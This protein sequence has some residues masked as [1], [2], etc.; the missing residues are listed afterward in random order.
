MLVD[1]RARPIF[2]SRAYIPTRFLAV[3]P[4]HC[5]IAWSC[6][7]NIFL[8]YNDIWLVVRRERGMLLRHEASFPLPSAI[9][10]CVTSPSQVCP[11]PSHVLLPI[12][13]LEIHPWEC[14]RNVKQNVTHARAAAQKGPGIALGNLSGMWCMQ[15][16][17]SDGMSGMWH[18]Q[19]WAVIYARPFAG[20]SPGKAMRFVWTFCYESPCPT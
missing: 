5:S 17:G 14:K 2:S 8:P 11:A 16:L 13:I 6:Q 19:K 18:M 15:C 3:H 7:P 1:D 10:D 20:Q 4:S 9:L 12:L